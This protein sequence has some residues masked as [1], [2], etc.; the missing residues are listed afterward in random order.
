M[1]PWQERVRNSQALISAHKIIEIIDGSDLSVLSPELRAKLERAKTVSETIKEKLENS[2]SRLVSTTALTNLNNNM[3]TAASY[4]TSWQAGNGEGYINNVE[5]E[6]DAA[7]VQLAVLTPDQD[8]PEAREAITRLRRS[9]AANITAADNLI[10]RLKERGSEADESI[11]QKVGESLTKF[12][13]LEADLAKLDEELSAIRT[14]STTAI[15]E[16]TSAYTKAEADRSSKFTQQINLNQQKLTEEF[17]K[18]QSEAEKAVVNVKSSVEADRKSIEENKLEV[19]RLL[20]IVGEEALIGDF[21]KRA[22]NEVKFAEGWAIATFVSILVAIVC[23]F[24]FAKNV[25]DISQN[26]SVS[27]QY[28]VAKILVV[29]SFG[30][31][32]AY[33]ARQS[34]EHRTSQRDSE[35]MA[36]QLSALPLYA[37]NIS[38]NSSRDELLILVAEKLFGRYNPPQKKKGSKDENPLVITQLTEA[39]IEAVR[40][41]HK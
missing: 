18:I 41:I 35:S 11:D 31:L 9:V 14:A 30:A 24:D 1:D 40:Q 32:A 6:M 38:K 20:Q 37:K 4:I 7:V 29:A 12:Q 33:A 16:Q 13:A 36:L 26:S 2:D 39:L 15:T 17:E 19:E 23:A 10:E 28:M 21:S 5:S 34:S 27:W 25:A 3:A 22:K 8:V